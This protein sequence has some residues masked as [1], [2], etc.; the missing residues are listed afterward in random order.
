MFIR[1]LSQYRII[2]L[3]W[4]NSIIIF[5]NNLIILECPTYCYDCSKY[6]ACSNCADGYYLKDGKCFECDSSCKTCSNGNDDSCSAC[7]DSYYI[8]LKSGKCKSHCDKGFYE[9]VC[10]IR[11]GSLCC[12]EMCGDGLL[13]TLPCDDKNT[14]NGDGCSSTCNIESEF[15]CSYDD[16]NMLSICHYI[17]PLIA[18]ISLPYDSAT[19]IQ[20]Q[21]NQPIIN[22]N[23][24]LLQYISLSV[25]IHNSV[26]SSHLI[27]KNNMTIEIDI[28][29][30]KS[31]KSAEI[32]VNF[33]NLDAFIGPEN[34]TLQKRILTQQL[35]NYYFYSFKEQQIQNSSSVASNLI[36]SSSSFISVFSLLATYF[37]GLFWTILS[38]LQFILY[39]SLINIKYPDN[40]K[41]VLKQSF[42]SPYS[43][44][45][46]YISTYA[47]KQKTFNL[48]VDIFVKSNFN[49][50][51][52]INI[53]SMIIYIAILLSINSLL[54]LIL[55]LLNKPKINFLG[56]E[57]C[58]QIFLSNAPYLILSIMLSIFKISY[59]NWFTAISNILSYLLFILLIIGIHGKQMK[60]YD[61]I[62]DNIANLQVLYPKFNSSASIFGII[63]LLQ[64]TAVSLSLIIF[65]N[66]TT[67]NTILIFM[68][69]LI[70]VS[71][72]IIYKPS[73]NNILMIFSEFGNLILALI[74]VIFALDDKYDWFTEEKKIIIGWVGIVC[75][76]GNLISQV[77]LGLF[78]FIRK[79]KSRMQNCCKKD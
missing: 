52:I 66:M 54:A 55:W 77:L 12:K 36:G 53:G 70:Y 26:N 29:Y 75:V 24:N 42:Q 37:S 16:I 11:T 14:F 65:E 31:F 18:I 59:S 58:F 30:N 74:S 64:M 63:D 62:D 5:S 19:F 7:Q 3:F 76:F 47:P 73:A 50:I 22:W 35:P 56:Y 21:F 15:F 46:N 49:S 13:F 34:Q 9:D 39:L 72:L 48:H 60:E 10:D 40:F 25:S 71:L 2:N 43:F 69:K 32:I 79:H 1:I 6:D 51:F 23:Q 17:T 27:F 67:V 4:Y 78:Q 28:N 45:P 68:I 8:D 20:I 41:R 38:A 33:L 44:I 57:Q 61:N